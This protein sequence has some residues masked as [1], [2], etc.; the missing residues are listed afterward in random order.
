MRCRETREI[1]STSSYGEAQI[2]SK[3]SG[4]QV[5]PMSPGKLRLEAG[6]ILCKVDG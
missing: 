2:F 5:L 4:K 1:C 6:C 3:H